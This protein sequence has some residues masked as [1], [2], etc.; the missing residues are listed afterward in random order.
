MARIVTR[1]N[2]AMAFIFLLAVRDVSAARDSYLAGELASLSALSADA[3]TEQEERNAAVRAAGSFSIDTMWS[4]GDDTAWFSSL[5]WLQ[6]EVKFAYKDGA[7]GDVAQYVEVTGLDKPYRLLPDTV[8]LNQEINGMS[9]VGIVGYQAWDSKT[10]TYGSSVYNK[11]KALFLRTEKNPVIGVT[12]ELSRVLYVARQAGLKVYKSNKADAKAYYFDGGKVKTISEA[13]VNLHATPAPDVLAIKMDGQAD[14]ALR[15]PNLELMTAVDAMLGQSSCLNSPSLCAF[16]CT[17]DSEKDV[18]GPI[19]FCHKVSASE[20]K[21]VLAPF[22]SDQKCKAVGATTHEAADTVLTD[23]VETV[24]AMA[25]EVSKKMEESE[26][27]GKSD[28]GRASMKHTVGLWM[29]AGDLLNVLE[30]LPQRLG[31]QAGKFTAAARRAGQVDMR[32]WRRAPQVLTVSEY[33]AA[34]AKP[35]DQL[36]HGH[37]FSVVAKLHSELVNFLIRRP[38]VLINAVKHDSK[39]QCVLSDESD[40][41]KAQIT[42]FAKYYL[43]AP[44]HNKDDLKTTD[45]SLPENCQDFLAGSDQRD[46]EDVAS[47]L[48]EST[49]A[50]EAEKSSGSLMQFK[51]ERLRDA[52]GGD[53]AASSFAHGTAFEGTEEEAEAAFVFILACIIVAIVCMLV[54]GML[55]MAAG[56]MIEDNWM[57]YFVCAMLGG[58]VVFGAFCMAWPVGLVV[59]IGSVVGAFILSSLAELNEKP[60]SHHGKTL[61]DLAAA[62]M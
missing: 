25:L 20:A 33:E 18:C 13:E 8:V 23:A 9:V 35:V 34:A 3:K 49:E 60:I 1:Q 61:L 45:L 43:K 15:K 51:S 37:G 30:T 59:L 24:K 36:T 6:S 57:G 52:V 19:G 26:A 21:S 55:F 31:D 29:E 17:Y 44:G 11:K 14:K 2:L 56:S 41:G 32:H 28:A 62:S 12:T 27:I 40:A 16:R 50:L 54:A 4:K 22:G 46:P 58:L 10:S 42:L 48:E 39:K 38:A 5:T 53:E 7:A 47:N